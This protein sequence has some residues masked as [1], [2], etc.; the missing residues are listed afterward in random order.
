[1]CNV[2]NMRG[3]TGGLDAAD[4]VAALVDHGLVG[5]VDVVLVHDPCADGAALCD[6]V[7]GVEPVF[8]DAEVVA[9]IEALGPRVVAGG[10]R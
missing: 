10:A 7:P 3:E 6:D 1:M 4:H 8:A 2:A 5:A 9:R